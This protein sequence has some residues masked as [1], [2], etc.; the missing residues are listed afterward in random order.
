MVYYQG[1]NVH[2]LRP[3][4]HRDLLL[5]AR[6]QEAW[7]DGTIDSKLYTSPAHTSG[8]VQ[9]SLGSIGTRNVTICS[10]V[11]SESEITGFTE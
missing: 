11:F 7:R 10:F 2:A 4:P 3:E 1:R 8:Q 6:V 9:L 5:K